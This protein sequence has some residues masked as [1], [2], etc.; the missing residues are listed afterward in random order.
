MMC[1]VSKTQPSKAF[2]HDNVVGTNVTEHVARDFFNH[3]GIGLIRGEERDIPL[4]LRAHGLEALDLEIQERGSFDQLITSFEAVAAMKRM[5][6]KVGTRNQASK[7]H[8][9]LPNAGT[10]PDL[11]FM[12]IGTQ[13]GFTGLQ[14]FGGSLEHEKDFS[15]GR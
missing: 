8:Q 13:H 1:K 9:H 6:S 5:K 7:Q 15:G 4:E 12:R 14:V 10:G 3:V 2:R 11:D